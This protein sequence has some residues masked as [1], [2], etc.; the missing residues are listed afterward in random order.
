MAEKPILFNSEMVLAIMDGRKTQTRRVI[1]PQPN[2][3]KRFGQPESEV[4]A[5][6]AKRKCSYGKV[7]DR[8]WV[9][10][11]FALNYQYDTDSISDWEECNSLDSGDP[12]Y[13]ADYIRKEKPGYI[14]RWRTNIH[15]PKWAARIWL[16]IIGVRVE[17]VQDISEED[18]EA[19]GVV[20]QEIKH[21][22]EIAETIPNSTYCPHKLTFSELWDSIN[23]KRG[24]GWDENPW[25]WV[26]EFNKLKGI[27][28]DADSNNATE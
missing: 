2:Y 6:I 27:S 25:V 13:R 4:N 21:L 22:R 1:K 20:P 7:G 15:M 3:Q 28:S 12:R 5:D 9:R 10:E 16:E 26:I 24:F 14:G 18:A 19:E 11:T 17:R 23:D 8:L